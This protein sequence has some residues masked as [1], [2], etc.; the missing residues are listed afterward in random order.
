MGRT[1]CSLTRA[2]RLRGWRRPGLRP[3]WGGGRFLNG[4]GGRRGRSPRPAGPSSARRT[5]ARTAAGWPRASGWAA[6]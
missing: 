4:G 2:K 3:C 6:R 1:A 5:A